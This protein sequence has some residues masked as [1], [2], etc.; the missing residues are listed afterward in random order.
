MQSIEIFSAPWILA[1]GTVFFAAFIRGVSG[2]GF[3]L[4]LAPILLLIVNPKEMVVIIMFLGFLGHALVLCRAYRNVDLKRV[5]PIMVS[6]LFGIPLGVWIINAIAPSHLKIIVGFIILCFT[7][8]IAF[9]YYKS[10]ANERLS[11]GLAGFISGILATSTSLAGPPIVLFMHSQNWPKEKIYPNLAAQL[12]VLTTSSLI[13]LSISGDVKPGLIITAASFAPVMF[14][15]IYAGMFLFRWT[16]ARF[17]K[18]LSTII[19]ICAAILGI[20]SGFGIILQ[21]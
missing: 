12:M 16:S 9:G 1:L 4:V 14:I 13:A 7:I 5:L 3:A 17:F 6:S 15:G 18:N 21:P 8:P 10:F 20:L 2:F 11:G 19:V